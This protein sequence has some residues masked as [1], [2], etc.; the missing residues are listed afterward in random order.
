MTKQWYRSKTVWLNLVTALG[1]ALAAPEI[2]AV[3]PA[4]WVPVLAA[5]NVGGNII[6]RVW[7]T[8][9]PIRSR[10]AKPVLK[11]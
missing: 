1:I 6:L 5:V 8:D 3:L 7:Y 9:R 10:R 2:L 11:G 4:S